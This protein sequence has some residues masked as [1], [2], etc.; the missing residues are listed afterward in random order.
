MGAFWGVS[1][2]IVRQNHSIPDVLSK[3]AERTERT[4]S[5]LRGH[6]AVVVPMFR[7]QI[8][9][10]SVDRHGKLAL[11]SEILSI[12]FFHVV[13]MQPPLSSLTFCEAIDRFRSIATWVNSNLVFW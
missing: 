11:R 12:P 3:L 1:Y 2:V 8:M 9:I 4:H 5:S 13:K 10:A 6:D 7:A